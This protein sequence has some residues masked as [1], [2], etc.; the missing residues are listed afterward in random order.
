MAVAS[1]TAVLMM[2]V[3]A[4]A[5]AETTSLDMTDTSD[6]AFV[7]PKWSEKAAASAAR[8]G[9]ETGGADWITTPGSPRAREGNDRLIAGS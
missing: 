9:A 2:A 8:A 5:H 1:L 6:W 3:V 7:G 4:V